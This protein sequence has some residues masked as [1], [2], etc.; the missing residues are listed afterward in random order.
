MARKRKKSNP[1]AADTSDGRDGLPLAGPSPPGPIHASGSSRTLR[2]RKPSRPSSHMPVSL[3]RQP[4]PVEDRLSEPHVKRARLGAHD[5]MLVL[6]S[7]TAQSGSVVAAESLTNPQPSARSSRIATQN[8]DL[9]RS[10]DHGLASARI[11]IAGDRLLST[12]LDFGSNRPHPDVDH[13]ILRLPIP[14]NNFELVE[15]TLEH[16]ARSPSP[17]PGQS[18]QLRSSSTSMFPPHTVTPGPTAEAP[19]TSPSVTPWEA[20]SPSQK[21]QHETRCQE[22]LTA[23]ESRDP[24]FRLQWANYHHFFSAW[25]LHYTTNERHALQLLHSHPDLGKLTDAFR[26]ELG[27]SRSPP[28]LARYFYQLIHHG[29]F[30][31]F[32]LMRL[33]LIGTAEVWLNRPIVPPMRT[34]CTPSSFILCREK[35]TPF[36]SA[37]TPPPESAPP[38]KNSKL[39]CLFAVLH[40]F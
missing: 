18:S 27:G 15:A 12:E 29:K 2:P 23:S 28:E 39:Y 31:E 35:L 14:A 22:L 16:S 1:D 24:D 36:P 8:L 13:N 33:L 32:T 9:A 11:Q 19:S 20:L 21:T 17:N 25:A 38:P 40:Q 10:P 6:S 26:H 37:S 34:Y 4:A 30:F 5:A 7:E 3:P